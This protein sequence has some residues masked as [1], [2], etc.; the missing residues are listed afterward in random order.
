MRVL[1]YPMVLPL[2]AIC[3]SFTG[4]VYIVGG[5]KKPFLTVGSMD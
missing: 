2:C 3:S 4:L 1:V 5:R